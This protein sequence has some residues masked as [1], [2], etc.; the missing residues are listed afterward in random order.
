MFQKPDICVIPAFCENLPHFY[1]HCVIT[2]K[3]TQKRNHYDTY[4]NEYKS[5]FYKSALSRDSNSEQ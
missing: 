5:T 2:K 1:P 3:E 4:K